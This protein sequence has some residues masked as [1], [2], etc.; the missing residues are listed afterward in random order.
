MVSVSLIMPVVQKVPGIQLTLGSRL[1]L[2]Y[3]KKGQLEVFAATKTQK[4][5]ELHCS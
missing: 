5:L 3:L 1:F 4:P 2:C